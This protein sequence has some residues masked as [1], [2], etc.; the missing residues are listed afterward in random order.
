LIFFIKPMCEMKTKFVV[1]VTG[2]LVFSC[3]EP[4]NASGVKIM[5]TITLETGGYCRDLDFRDSILVAA[6][7]EMGY[8]VFNFKIENGEFSST[9]AYGL[10]T[11][12]SPENGLQGGGVLIPDAYDYFLMM[13]QSDALYYINF[14]DVDSLGR[15]PYPGSENRDYMR[16]FIPA[17]STEDSLVIYTLN[18]SEDGNSTF[19]SVRTVVKDNH[20]II[21]TSMNKIDIFFSDFD[22]IENLNSDAQSLFYNGGL[23]AVANSQLGII[24]FQESSDGV[25]NDIVFAAYDTPLGGAVETVHSSGKTIFAG[26]GNDDGCFVVQ[27]S[28]TG[29]VAQ[30]VQLAEGYSVK[31]IHLKDGTLAL[32]CGSDGVLLY[33]WSGFGE[34]A[35]FSEMGRLDSDYAYN[36]KIYDRETIFAATRSGVQVF[37]IGR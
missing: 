2:L 27:L 9:K 11:G 6:A 10:E 14:S 29:T 5:N 19:I 4:E 33:E 37:Q 12:Q 30:S 18:R 21:D 8:A 26:Q 13:D 16:N 24:V 15:F 20:F 31:G 28:D 3:I 35:V 34:G 22:Q 7:D 1:M 25:L 17:K 36:V 32:A 23:V